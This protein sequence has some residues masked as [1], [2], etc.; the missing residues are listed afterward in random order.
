MKVIN[1]DLKVINLDLDKK[2][3]RKKRLKSQVLQHVTYYT[4]ERSNTN[5][6]Q[7]EIPS[8]HNTPRNKLRYKTTSPIQRNG[9]IFFGD[10]IFCQI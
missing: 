8:Q 3:R 6:Q 4:M 5:K 10:K 9:T 7:T 1:L 2:K